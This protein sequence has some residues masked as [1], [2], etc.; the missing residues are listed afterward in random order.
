MMERMVTAFVGS[1]V[2]AIGVVSMACLQAAGVQTP[3]ASWCPSADSA[4]PALAAQQPSTPPPEPPA[5]VVGRSD[6]IHISVSPDVSPDSS[7][8]CTGD[9]TVGADGMI[10]FC[11]LNAIEV[12]GLTERAIEALI[13]KQLQEK[14]YYENASVTAEVKTFRS[15]FVYVQ[16]QVRNPGQ[17]PL[18]GNEMTL[19]HAISNAGGLLTDAGPDIF[20]LRPRRSAAGGTAPVPIDDTNSEKFKY[21]RRALMDNL[22]QNPPLLDGDTVFVSQAELFYINGEVKSP[23]QKVWEPCMT[24]GEAIAMAGGPSEKWS[25]RRSHIQR[26]NAKNTFDRIGRLKPETP[27]LPRDVL[28]IGRSLF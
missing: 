14:Q 13:K 1:C 7:G 22:E 28:V 20:I 3:P 10:N 18:Q 25:L 19:M 26:K 9:Y 2:V 27:L 15:Q 11:M 24:V 17:L 16:G 8:R 12:E 21:S 23:G 5:Y 6:M 4:A